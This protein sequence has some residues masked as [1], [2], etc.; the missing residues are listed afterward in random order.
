M[1]SRDVGR[2]GERE[3]GKWC[4]SVGIDANAS[5]VDKTGWDFVIELPFEEGAKHI[6][7]SAVEARVQV[8]STDKKPGEVQ[9]KLSNLRRLATAPCP[10]FIVFLEFDG[11]DDPQRAYL[12]HIDEQLINKILRRIQKDLNPVK[13]GKGKKRKKGK[14]KKPRKRKP[15]KKSSAVQLHKKKVTVKYKEKHQL[16]KPNGKSLKSA[17]L[18]AVPKGLQKYVDAKLRHLESTGFEDGYGLVNFTVEGEE[19]LSKLIDVSLG[20]DDLVE[21][22]D[23]KSSPSRFGIFSKKD[24]KS[25][26]QAW[27]GMPNLKPTMQGKLKF[28]QNGLP[29]PLVF[30]ADVYNSPFN[31]PSEPELAKLR[32]VVDCFEIHLRPF[33]RQFQITFSIGGSKP[34]ELNHLYRL[35][36]L[37]WMLENIKQGTTMKLCIDDFTDLDFDFGNK[38]PGMEFKVNTQDLSNAAKS[39]IALVN[40][41][42]ITETVEVTM[43]QLNQNS[44]NIQEMALIVGGERRYWRNVYPG[45]ALVPKPNTE[46]ASVAFGSARIG[47]FRVGQFFVLC[48]SPIEV[49]DGHRLETTQCHFEGRMVAD[50]GNPYD[51]EL[52]VKLLQQ[53][54]DKYKSDHQIFVMCGDEV[55]ERLLLD[56]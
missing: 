18:D 48:G 22:K 30:D 42:E 50:R 20:L 51:F 40:E 27:I 38:N 19:N 14:S 16:K 13:K 39:A 31:S 7:D 29:V 34:I 12:V 4:D 43:S 44:S 15:K 49:G 26:A 46:L 45:D 37:M 36:R 17:L 24:E 11:E 53:I 9:I 35:L 3:F 23:L 5:D 54:I 1:S 32:I 2:M 21:V 33:V 41:F 55:A 52:H 25:L 6:H 47:E 10:T 56:E 28:S 8:K